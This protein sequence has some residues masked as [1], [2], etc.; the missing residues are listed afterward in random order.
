MTFEN[1]K[2]REPYNKLN[3][4][5]WGIETKRLPNLKGY[6]KVKNQT[7]EDWNEEALK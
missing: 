6:E 5:L 2:D 3:P 7:L 4:D 1:V